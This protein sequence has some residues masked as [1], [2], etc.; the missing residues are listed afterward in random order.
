V[1]A[2]VEV[3]D[4]G[5]IVCFY[6]NVTIL[7]ARSRHEFLYASF[8]EF[9]KKYAGSAYFGRSTQKDT[10][11]ISLTKVGVIRCTVASTPEK[12]RLRPTSVLLL[13]VGVP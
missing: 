13:I 12:C 3:V 10:R 11:L 2:A 5:L 6:V 8:T 7:E 9:L 4:A 1:V